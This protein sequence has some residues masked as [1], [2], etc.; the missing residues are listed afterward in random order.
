MGVQTPGTSGG[1][2][3]MNGAQRRIASGV[4]AG[5]ALIL[6][7]VALANAESMLSDLRADGVGETRAHI[8][9]WEVTSIAAWITTMPFIWW[10]VAHVRPPRFGWLAVMALG[11]L[12]S[13]PVSLTHVGLMVAM[14][15]ALYTLDGDTY[16]FFGVIADRLL[17]EYRKDLVTFLQFAAVAAMTQW[18]LARAATPV[19]APSAPLTIDVPDGA[20][21]HRLPV[22]E[23]DQV[24]AAGNYVELHWRGRALLHRATL[25]AVEAEL[26][27]GFVRIHRSRLVRHAAI[28]QVATDKSGDFTVTLADG[29]KARG[30]RRYRAGVEP[31]GSL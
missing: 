10:L 2:R 11:L 26:G 4:G 20:V 23:I 27:G 5:F 25:A 15:K 1:W 14:R 7:L 9:G 12:A 18:L 24:T 16:R 28:R 31:G 8:W 21:T 22:G 13:V 3:G 6:C 19:V 17:Y 30:S 29:T